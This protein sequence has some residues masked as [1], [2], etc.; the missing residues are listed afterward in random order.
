MKEGQ[1]ITI[2]SERGVITKI[3]Q[4]PSLGFPSYRITVELDRQ[5]DEFGY[6]AFEGTFDVKVKE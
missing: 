4:L 5:E 6:S 2:G 3:E 1:P